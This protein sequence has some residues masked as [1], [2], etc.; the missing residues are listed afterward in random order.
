MEETEMPSV[1]M[2]HRYFQQLVAHYLKDAVYLTCGRQLLTLCCT[3][4]PVHTHTHGHTH[5]R[6]P[7]DV[8]NDNTYAHAHCTLHESAKQKSN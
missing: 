4:M 1:H 7:C 5:S 6:K 3:H 8:N 2:C